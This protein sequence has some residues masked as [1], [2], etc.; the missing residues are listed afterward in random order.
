MEGS[1]R[2]ADSSDLSEDESEKNVFTISEQLFQKLHEMGFSENAIKKSI[3]SGCVDEATCTQWITMHAGHPE[4]DT[5]LAEGVVVNVKAKRYLTEEEREAKIQELRLKAKAKK[6]A[7]KE[8]LHKKELERIK[9]GREAIDAER[10]RKELIRQQEAKEKELEKQR[11]LLARRRVKLQVK[12]DKLVRKG[13]SEEEARGIAEA[14]LKAEEAAEAEAE[15]RRRAERQATLAASQAA[16]ASAPPRP[17]FVPSTNAFSVLKQIYDEPA[18]SLEEAVKLASQLKA[19]AA[20]GNAAAQAGCT[21]LSTILHNIVRDPLN[22]KLRVLKTTTGAFTNKI[23]PA[24]D[25]IRLLRFCNFDVA[26][27]AEG[28][29]ILINNAVVIRLLETILQ[30]IC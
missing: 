1:K 3:A 24:P 4:L 9:F 29:Q 27:N 21:I 22:N 25:V 16:A 6:E 2:R 7:E 19:N 17:L 15:A 8:E 13:R 28:E 11:D 5:P 14:E 30:G 23:L 10:R 26:E 18:L 12:V 20:G